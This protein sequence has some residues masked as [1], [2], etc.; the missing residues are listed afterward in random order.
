MIRT[1]AALAALLAVVALLGASGGTKAAPPP[2]PELQRV[3]VEQ[4]GVPVWEVE[5]P[6]SLTPRECLEQDL[7]ADLM[8]AVGVEA[9][10][11]TRTLAFDPTA[12]KTG[13]W[14]IHSSAHPR[15]GA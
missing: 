5:C 15:P 10:S 3:W 14:T 8:D 9:T 12:P 4:D 7:A 1:T 2:A 11:A 13:D 6:T